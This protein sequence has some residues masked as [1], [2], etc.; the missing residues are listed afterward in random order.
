V[1][2]F[3]RR[4]NQGASRPRRTARAIADHTTA[5]CVGQ[6]C[7]TYRGLTN[8][9]EV[10]DN[11]DRSLVRKVARAA[12]EEMMRLLLGYAVAEKRPSATP[13]PAKP[14]PDPSLN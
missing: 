12:A 11:T 8:T 6:E 4:P 3:E 13:A 14:V 5:W 9:Y 10:G 7:P 2:Q 1:E